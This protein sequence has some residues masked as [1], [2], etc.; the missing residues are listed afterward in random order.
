[1]CPAFGAVIENTTELNNYKKIFPEFCEEVNLSLGDTI[2]DSDTLKFAYVN[3]DKQL[4][5]LQNNFIAVF[6]KLSKLPIKSDGQESEQSDQDEAES[7]DGQDQD[8]SQESLE[9][10][11]Q[12]ESVNEIFIYK[13]V[14]TRG[15]GSGMRK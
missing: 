5:Q 3:G 14:N 8:K 10:Q 15:P 1:M 7:Q 4:E 12:Q 13:K 11:K 9:A 2:L 6:S